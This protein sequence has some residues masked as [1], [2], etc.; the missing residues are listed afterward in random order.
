MAFR[1]NIMNKIEKKF[2]KR[3]YLFLID[4]IKC[5]Q[6]ITRIGLEWGITSSQDL[7]TNYCDSPAQ[8]VRSIS[9]RKNI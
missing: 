6:K 1:K 3:F 2:F 8:Y 4:D 7:Q 9:F 5:Y